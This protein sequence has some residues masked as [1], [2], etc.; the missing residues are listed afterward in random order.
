M[1]QAFIIIG[2]TG[3]YGWNTIIDCINSIRKYNNTIP[4]ILVNNFNEPC[5][6]L[7]LSD[8]NIR[9]LIN[10]DNTYELG[11]I[12]KVIY[13]TNDIDYYYIIHDSC[14]ILDTIVDILCVKD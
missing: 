3:K 7:F 11:A 10:E 12:K 1:K 13:N 5:L 8:N 4:I 2:Y 14:K 9:Y 6:D